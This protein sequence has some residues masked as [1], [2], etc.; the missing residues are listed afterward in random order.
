MNETMLFSSFSN[1]EKEAQTGWSDLNVIQCYPL[2][3]EDISLYITFIY[4]G[5][6]YR[7]VCLF[8]F[9]RDAFISFGGTCL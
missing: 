5:F 7:F 3:T 9:Y 2:L 4:V 8:F 6:I 1:E